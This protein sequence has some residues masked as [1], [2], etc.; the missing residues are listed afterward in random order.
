MTT[1]KF[2]WG[3][4]C[5]PL[6][7]VDLRVAVGALGGEHGEHRA[8]FLRS[9]QTLKHR[10]ASRTWHADSRLPAVVARPWLPGTRWRR[11]SSSHVAGG[12]R[13]GEG[14]QRVARLGPAQPRALVGQRGGEQQHGDPHEHHDPHH[15][16]VLVARRAAPRA[17]PR[18]ASSGSGLSRSSSS[19]RSAA[20]RLARLPEVAE[21]VLSHGRRGAALSRG[22]GSGSRGPARTG[23]EA[24]ARPARARVQVAQ[25]ERAVLLGPH[26]RGGQHQHH[27]EQRH[28]QVDHGED[29]E[30]AQH[31]DVG[32]DQRGEAGDGGH[33]RGQ[34][35]GARGAVGQLDRPRGRAPASRSWR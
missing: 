32:G 7:A 6:H 5:H 16:R 24:P 21:A 23:P 12:Q 30:V 4:P 31:P 8:G 2:T 11:K 17:A 35:G 29:P 27:A 3:T 10:L 34:H 28:A 13:R 14:R 26:Q 20:L 22:R 15:P 1:A 18:R 19:K 33:A 25:G 9:S